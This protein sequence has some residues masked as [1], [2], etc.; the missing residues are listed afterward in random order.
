MGQVVGQHKFW[1]LCRCLSSDRVTCL[2]ACDSMRIAIL[3]PGIGLNIHVLAPAFT[4][5][6]T[7]NKIILDSSE[8]LLGFSFVSLCLSSPCRCTSSKLT[9]VR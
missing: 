2:L 3:L 7:F 5:V 9:R 6:G 1:F 8:S 4:K